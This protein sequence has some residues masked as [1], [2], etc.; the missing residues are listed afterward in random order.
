MVDGLGNQ[1]AAVLR[2][3][4]N[5]AK[6]EWKNTI[7]F[8]PFHQLSTIISSV[9][10]CVCVCASVCVCVCA[11]LCVH[12]MYFVCVYLTNWE[13]ILPE[14]R[15]IIVNTATHT[16]GELLSSWGCSTSIMVDVHFMVDIDLLKLSTNQ[17]T[18]YTNTSSVFF[19][20]TSSHFLMD[21]IH[22]GST[23]IWNG[24]LPMHSRAGQHI[25][26]VLVLWHETRYRLRFWISW[27]GRSVVFSSF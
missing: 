9:Y 10:V 24:R 12:A 1:N 2:M 26:I 16:P 27:Y 20:V 4:R 18:I 5:K 17:P 22:N 11:W 25:D 23:K 6:T 21:T 3:T 8:L 19:H 7:T 15:P 13:S 14:T